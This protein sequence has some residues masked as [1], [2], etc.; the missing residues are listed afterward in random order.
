MG[1]ISY[2]NT[3]QGKANRLNLNSNLTNMYTV[4]VT[5]D[6]GIV[7][8]HLSNLMISCNT[9]NEAW[10][11]PLWNVLS[12]PE[13]P[14]GGLVEVVHVHSNVAQLV[15]G[16]G[17]V[18][19]RGHQG[20]NDDLCVGQLESNFE[21]LQQLDVLL[22]QSV[23]CVLKQAAH[24]SHSCNIINQLCIRVELILKLCIP[25]VYFRGPPWD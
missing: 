11:K 17:V 9:A 25:Q 23:R 2:T 6:H 18:G 3:K 7:R 24:L 19:F 13:S 10:P 5:L 20:G 14:H 16:F 15:V 1:R 22:S 21:F 4:T 8:G 12:Q